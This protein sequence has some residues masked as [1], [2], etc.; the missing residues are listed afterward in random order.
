IMKVDG[1]KIM[2]IGITTVDIMSSIQTDVLGS[3]VNIEDAAREV[4]RICNIYRS[5]DIDFTILLTHIGFEEDKRLAAILDPDWGVDVIV[6][7]HTHTILEHPEKVN[8]ILIVQAGVGTEQIG[9]FDIVVNTDTNSVYDYQWQTVQITEE[10][11]P[12]DYEMEKVIAHF[13]EETDEKYD[14]VLC[15]L[16]H[17][18]THP[19]RYQ[20]T[21]LGNLLSDILKEELGFDLM[22]LGSGSV[23]RESVPTVM[24]MGIFQELFPYDDK[25]RQVTVTGDQLAR[26]I[27][28]VFR[29]EMFE[30][31]H[32]EFYQYS[33]GMRIVY[34]R[35]KKDFDAFELAG[36]PIEK[37]GLYTIGLQDFHFV[38]FNQFF[39]LS[40]DEV[41]ENGKARVVTTSAHDVMVEH[42]ASSLF[43]SAE[44]EGRIVIEQ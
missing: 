43:V 8:D 30:S 24:T 27:R 35:E 13:K 17:E 39:G 40:V 25:I 42:L 41:L 26:M 12:H 21:Q 37:D 18:L 2:F 20:E 34:N 7:G 4:G 9:R 36:K 38:N 1:M 19:S 29:D 28:Y 10:N 33:T 6:G 22:V 15:R 14:R 5:V 32:T 31:D 16:A 11:C 23:R 44:I 3:F